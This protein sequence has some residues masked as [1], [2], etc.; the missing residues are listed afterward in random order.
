ML[1]M[2][3]KKVSG[4]PLTAD[5]EPLIA[6]LLAD[7]FVLIVGSNKVAKASAPLLHL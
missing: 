1:V 3:P 4:A 2:P 5:K 7:S 6:E